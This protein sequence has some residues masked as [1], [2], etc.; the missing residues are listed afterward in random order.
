MFK[1]A[2]LN[3][4]FIVALLS[5][6]FI[7]LGFSRLSKNLDKD[8]KIQHTDQSEY[9]KSTITNKAILL[10]AEL[11][12]FGKPISSTL[13]PGYDLRLSGFV[14]G[15]W[16]S[17]KQ[18]KVDW[19]LRADDKGTI[20]IKFPRKTLNPNTAYASVFFSDVDS[21]IRTALISSGE[22]SNLISKLGGGQWIKIPVS[23]EEIDRGIKT[24]DIKTLTG[25]GSCISAITLEH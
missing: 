20:V 6:S 22:W 17:D 14:T 11:G 1:K 23:K 8:F 24:I 16:Y 5:V 25:H 4:T 7:L 19:H 2:I 13:A 18:L 12:R 15:R 10:F 21:N 9:T 3:T